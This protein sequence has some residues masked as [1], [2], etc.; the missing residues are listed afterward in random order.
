MEPDTEVAVGQVAAGALDAPVPVS[1]QLPVPVGAGK[2]PWERVGVTVAVNVKVA[3]LFAVAGF[4]EFA[5]V[6]VG[7]FCT[8]LIEFEEE[9]SV[10]AL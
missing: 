1:V 9:V 7:V 10:T 6:A 2:G 5:N 4:D 3:G 8:T